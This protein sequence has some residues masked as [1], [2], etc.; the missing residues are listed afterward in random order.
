MRCAAFTAGRLQRVDVTRD[1][2]LDPEWLRQEIKSSS[3]KRWFKPPII[4][5][6]MRAGTM[7]GDEQSREQAKDAD[8]VISPSLGGI[9]I[10]DWKAF[11]EAI[12][13]RLQLRQQ[14][15]S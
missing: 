8:L 12:E 1:L 3:I 14:G 15:P 7:T 11:E 9:E 6:L 2:A 13:D 10:R 5:V 4:S